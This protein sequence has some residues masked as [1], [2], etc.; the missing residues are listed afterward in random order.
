MPHYLILENSPGSLRK[1]DL[2]VAQLN[3][4]N[5]TKSKYPFSSYSQ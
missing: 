2:E 1:S 5:L 4:D 3:E